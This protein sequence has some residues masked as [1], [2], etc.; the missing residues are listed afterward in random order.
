MNSK[1][2]RTIQV[3]LRFFV[4][5]HIRTYISITVKKF[6]QTGNET[7]GKLE[8][9]RPATRSQ[10][11]D[12]FRLYEVGD[13]AQSLPLL[14][15]L[16]D[17]GEYP[18]YVR[19][20]SARDGDIFTSA[21]AAR[22]ICEQDNVPKEIQHF[23]IQ[24]SDV[25]DEVSEDCGHEE[26]DLTENEERQEEPASA[27]LS[28]EEQFVPVVVENIDVSTKEAAKSLVW[29]PTDIQFSDRSADDLGPYQLLP[30]R[31]LLP[32]LYLDN[33]EGADLEEGDSDVNAPGQ[34]SE[35]S[36]SVSGSVEF[37]SPF[38]ISVEET[39][40]QALAKEESGVIDRPENNNRENVDDPANNYEFS[41]SEQQ[42][43]SRVAK[44]HLRKA[45][46][47][48]FTPAPRAL[49]LSELRQFS[50]S[51]A[52][53][54]RLPEKRGLDIERNS[55]LPS[56]DIGHSRLPPI[57][58]S[59]PSPPP[60]RSQVEYRSDTSSESEGSVESVVEAGLLPE[61]DTT[62]EEIVAER[63]PSTSSPI[64]PNEGHL[65]DHPLEESA[66]Q[67]ENRQI[68][69]IEPVPVVVARTMAGRTIINIPAEIRPH[70]ENFTGTAG[71]NPEEWLN[72]LERYNKYKKLSDQAFLDTFSLY[73]KGHSLQWFESLADATK[74]SK[75]LLV[76]AFKA[77]F[78]PSDI[79]KLRSMSDL[80][81]RQQKP[82]ES[83][84]EYFTTMQKI[85]R[86]AGNISDG[87]LR[88]AILMGLKSDLKRHAIQVGPASLSE[89]LRCAKIAEE[90]N[91]AADQGESS[92][93]ETLRRIEQKLM[94]KD[95]GPRSI[96]PIGD[97]DTEEKPRYRSA[98]AGKVN[99]E[100]RQPRTGVRDRL[101]YTSPPPRGY[102]D[103]PYK[104]RF[105]ASGDPGDEEM[106]AMY[107]AQNY[108]Q[109]CQPQYQGQRSSYGLQRG[110]RQSAA[111]QPAFNNAGKQQNTA[112]D[113][114][115]S[116]EREKKVF[117]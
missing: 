10:K 102:E 108:S 84:D 44:S 51:W 70:P 12:L 29:D 21:A 33:L 113:G 111:Q 24:N 95:D 18:L 11:P 15:K 62:P 91:T 13:Q 3:T 30:V 35:G 31:F 93:G 117:F 110:G 52:G 100:R 6:S 78:Y 47:A 57:S 74:T 7:T 53:P 63:R 4:S 19:P 39:E 82:S 98:S 83:V 46:S 61:R 89:L 107:Q 80:F 87:N 76:E 65:A 25:H 114:V 9:K 104:V 64:G 48:F 59:S 34:I 67:I 94:E 42:D 17:T 99:E 32:D 86:R 97:S 116:D 23:E 79:E 85:A 54:W 115:Y 26:R 16:N 101:S 90:A 38:E 43:V 41:E 81:R 22:Y 14:G 45:T 112:G 1:R 106:S 5:A 68:V 27:S 77:R 60:E 75:A 71:E 8:T 88:S 72:F 2:Q 69:N 58:G 109:Q 49:P 56:F 37:P 28:S 73:L 66:I 40:K 50:S 96:T 55:G 36:I 105:D 20:L 92:F 103:R